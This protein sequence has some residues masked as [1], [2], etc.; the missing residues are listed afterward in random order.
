MTDSLDSTDMAKLLEEYP[1]HSYQSPDPA[2]MAMPTSCHSLLKVTPYL[3]AHSMYSPCHYTYSMQNTTTHTVYYYTKSLLLQTIYY[4]ATPLHIHGK[5]LLYDVTTLT[6][7]T[8]THQR[9]MV[10]ESPPQFQ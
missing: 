5:I 3:T 10:V 4:F 1:P 2:M 7:T 6:Y 9:T 8:A